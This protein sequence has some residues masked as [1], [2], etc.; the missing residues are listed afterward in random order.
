MMKSK[1]K[2]VGLAL[3]FV[4]AMAVPT[5]AGAGDSRAED[6]GLKELSAQWWQWALSIPESANPLNEFTDAGAVCMVGQR[7]PVW[8]LAGTLVGGTVSRKCSVPAGTAIFFPVVNSVIVNTPGVCGQT[9]PNT[10]AP[11]VYT[12]PEMRAAVA[13]FIDGVTK[14]TATIDGKAVKAIRRV[15]SEP[16]VG[17]LP[18]TTC[19][20]RSAALGGSPPG[21]TPPVSTTATTSSWK[22]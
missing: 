8:F 1:H 16:F 20:S 17:V 14:M 12:V 11:V 5:A 10:G 15:R 3:A 6:S 19:L 9:D 22:G 7:G 18:L 13:G 21:S 2:R 4:S